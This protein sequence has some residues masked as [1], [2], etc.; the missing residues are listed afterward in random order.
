MDALLRITYDP[1]D[2]SDF[3][4]SENVC[5][6]CYDDIDENNGVK[7]FCN[8][9][10]HYYCVND[11]LN[12][13]QCKKY[14]PYCRCKMSETIYINFKKIVLL[15]INWVEIMRTNNDLEVYI[16]GNT[17]Y[18]K[19]NGIIRNCMTSIKPVKVLI[20]FEDGTNKLVD[21]K[22]IYVLK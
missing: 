4:N 8:H 17:I 10:F 22:Y 9:K 13:T 2:M 1:K 15:P 6:I 12:S 3:I 14:C 18:S 11:I 7:L 21:K 5:M 20:E 16:Y 19:K